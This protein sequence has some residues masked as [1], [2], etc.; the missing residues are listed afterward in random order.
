MKH[1]L[2]DE[3]NDNI[4]LVLGELG[5]IDHTHIYTNDIRGCCPVHGGTNPTAFSYRTDY[6]IW[7][8]FTQQCHQRNQTIIGLISGIH[9]CSDKQAENWLKKLLQFE[10]VESPHESQLYQ[11]VQR[12]KQQQRFRAKLNSTACKMTP[13]PIEQANIAPDIYFK[14][15]GFTQET[16]DRFM[17]G[18]CDDPAKPMYNMAYAAVLDEIGRY[19][20]GVTGRTIFDKCDICQLHHKQGHGCPTDGTGVVAYPKWKH[21]GFNSKK[22]LYNFWDAKESIDQHESVVIVEGPKD[23]WWLVQN[24]VENVVA[25]FGLEISKAQIKKLMNAVVLFLCLDNDR[26]AIRS[27][28]MQKKELSKYFKLKDLSQL[29]PNNQDIADTSPQFIEQEILERV[30]NG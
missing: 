1:Q 27:V 21:W 17:I 3:A 8:C 11:I 13:M 25:I 2:I 23:A 5:L 22:V 19:I 7:R 20:I 15:K 9:G 29:L 10:E 26:H 4:E 24:G 14:N 12:Y 30:T 6:K 18:F 28:N 16:I